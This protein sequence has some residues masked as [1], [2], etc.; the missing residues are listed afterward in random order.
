MEEFEQNKL[1]LL[2]SKKLW[3]LL[4]LDQTILHTTML[5]ENVDLSKDI[6]IPHETL[7][8]TYIFRTK[9]SNIPHIVNFRPGVKE[10]LLEISEYYEIHIYTSGSMPYANSIVHILKNFVLKDVDKNVVNRIFG[11]RVI[12][13]DHTKSKFKF[14]TLNEFG[15][16]L[17]SR[18]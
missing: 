8:D 12:T 9:D 3:M 17:L 7:E 13:R 18:C 2:E 14:T 16:Y 5:G 11:S 4:D 6:C 15:I 10:F 1:K